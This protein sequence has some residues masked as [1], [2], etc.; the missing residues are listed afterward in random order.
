[1]H[2]VRFSGMPQPGDTPELLVS[3]IDSQAPPPEVLISSQVRLL[4]RS[5][6]RLKETN[7]ARRIFGKL[8]EAMYVK[9][10]VRMRHVISVTNGSCIIFT[11]NSSPN[12]SNGAYTETPSKCC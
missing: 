4:P 1:M 6:A 11:V 2:R 9:L 10:L 7:L 5:L 8:D 12:A 3:R